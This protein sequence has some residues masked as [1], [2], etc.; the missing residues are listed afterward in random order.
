M[1]RAQAVVVRR[2]PSGR[3]RWH[4]ID[5]GAGVSLASNHTFDDSD[6]AERSATAA[7]PDLPIERAGTETS[8]AAAEAKSR[9]PDDG[10]RSRSGWRRFLGL[11]LVLLLVILV[12]APRS[13]RQE[14]AP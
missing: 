1:S 6:S 8:E 2:L 7:Y 3:W 12:V 9:R 10:S 13:A 4:F 5:E 11:G 14:T